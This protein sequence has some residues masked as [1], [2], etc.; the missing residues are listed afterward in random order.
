MLQFLNITYVQMLP[1]TLLTAGY[2]LAERVSQ[3]LLELVPYWR[4]LL[5]EYLFYLVSLSH[6]ILRTESID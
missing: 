4:N 2:L 5:I 1:R 6:S 3:N